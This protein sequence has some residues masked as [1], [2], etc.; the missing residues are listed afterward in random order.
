MSVK[1]PIEALVFPHTG[2]WPVAPVSHSIS[3][4]IYALKSL[5]LCLSPWPRSPGKPGLGTVSEWWEPLALS[6]LSSGVA[7]VALLTKVF[8]SLV[9]G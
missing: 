7:G 4:Y 9:G 5:F 8:F 6:S 1:C 2:L 3:V